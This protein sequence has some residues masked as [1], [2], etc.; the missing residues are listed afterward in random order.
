[1]GIIILGILIELSYLC[2]EKETLIKLEILGSNCYII[3]K[4]CFLVFKFSL[5]TKA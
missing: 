1:M 4:D 3:A 2:K 5:G